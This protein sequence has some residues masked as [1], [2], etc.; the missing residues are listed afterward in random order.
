MLNT[1]IKDL[2]ENTNPDLKIFLIGNKSD[3]NSQ[4]E[5]SINDATNFC[6]KNE[7]F[8]FEETSA[9]NGINIEDI[10]K[11]AIYVIYEGYL[12]YVEDNK[13]KGKKINFYGSSIYD[14]VNSCDTVRLRDPMDPN[15]I[16]DRKESD[17]AV[18]DRFC[19]C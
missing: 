7:I 4:R 13:I 3:L 12:K 9:K 11:K 1:W 2:K 18:V 17:S 19:L 16:K 6:T 14:S 15:K 8:H 5:I 10:F